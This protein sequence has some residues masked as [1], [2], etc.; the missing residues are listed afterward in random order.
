M[1]KLKS[2]GS[3][4]GLCGKVVVAGATGVTSVRGCQK[5]PQYLTEAMLASSQRWTCHWPRQSQY[6][7]P[8]VKT[9]MKEIVSLQPVEV[10]GGVDIHLQPM[11]DTTLEQV[12]ARR[13]PMG[14]PH[15][16]RLQAVPV[17]MWKE[18]P[19]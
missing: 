1:S 5:L 6:L 18:D 11:E 3:V 7:H 13:M 19:H 2:K 17:A 14:S 4:F 16:S 10:N 9:V 15:W 8:L 12:N